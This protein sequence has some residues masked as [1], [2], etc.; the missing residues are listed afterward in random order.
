MN[1]HLLVG[2]TLGLGALAMWGMSKDSIEERWEQAPGTRGFLNLDDVKEAFQKNQKIEDF[3]KRLNEIYEG[4][5]LILL[6]LRKNPKAA[7]FVLT[8]QEDLNGNTNIDSQDEMLFKLTAADGKATLVG[9]GANKHYSASWPYHP[10]EFDIEEEEREQGRANNHYYPYHGFNS[11]YLW[12]GRPYITPW[13]HQE[14]ILGHRQNYRQTSG[15]AQQVQKNDQ[16]QTQQANLHGDKFART[17]QNLTSNRQQ[18]INNKL[19][20]ET[21][22]SKLANQQKS[23]GWG[24]RQ[25]SGKST[26]GGTKSSGFAK[27]VSSFK[28]SAG[29]RI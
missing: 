29:V 13:S 27:A 16:F 12:G 4:D 17:Q 15:F 24:V 1:K 2:G 26:S 6:D 28:S 14:S 23:S 7:G 3:E 22:R 11:Y 25:A 5:N 8:G 21:F 20:S 10:E 9:V 19:Q 18:H